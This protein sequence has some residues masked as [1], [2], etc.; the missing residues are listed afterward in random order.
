M[1]F[2]FSKYDKLISLFCVIPIIVGVLSLVE[3]FLPYK[4]IEATVKFKTIHKGSYDRI[5]H[6]VYFENNLEQFTKEI[7]D[8]LNIGDSVLLK[9]TFFSEQTEEIILNKRNFINSTGEKYASIFI[10]IFFLIP[11][12]FWFKKKGLSNKKYLYLISIIAISAYYGIE[13]ML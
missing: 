1:N 8:E 9:V 13:F 11:G 4:K 5:V 10:S 6:T 7:Y 12:L 2:T 3:I